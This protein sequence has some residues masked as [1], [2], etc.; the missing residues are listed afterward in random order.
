MKRIISVCG[1]DGSDDHLSRYALETAENVGR[2][3]ARRGGVVVC[4]GRGGIMRAVC[5]GAKEENGIT[6]GIL[7]ESKEEAN[8]FVDVVIATGMGYSRNALVAGTA[9]LVVAF[10]GKYGTLSEVGFALNAKKAVYG[11]GTW[12]IPGVEKLE[13][14]AELRGI[15]KKRVK[16]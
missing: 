3:I 2:C 9:D 8:E 5:K 11:F 7:P 4:G 13:S 16:G 1:S 6:V 14:P 12:D 15:L 10:P